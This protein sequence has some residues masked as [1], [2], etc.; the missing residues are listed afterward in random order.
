MWLYLRKFVKI[1][2]QLWNNQTRSYITNALLQYTHTYELLCKNIKDLVN[3]HIYQ[4]YDD[5]IIRIISS[6]KSKNILQNRIR[7]IAH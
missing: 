5:T 6:D 1:Q 2:I 4:T 7:Y 3:V